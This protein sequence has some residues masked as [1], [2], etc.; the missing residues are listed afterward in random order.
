[1]AGNITKDWNF[2]HI[3][4]D[5]MTSQGDDPSTFIRPGIDWFHS[6]AA[7]YDAR[8]N[9][10][11]VSSREN[12]LIKVNYDTGNII[13]IFGDPTKYWYTFPSLRAK[14]ITLESGGLYPIG[15][16]ATSITSDGLL[17]LFND[18]QGSLNQ[19][20]NTPAGETRS[21]SAVSAY[22]IDGNALTAKEVWRF[23]YNQSIFSGVCSSAYEADDKSLL[24]NYAVADHQ[25]KARLVGLNK[26][27]DVIFD[28]EYP[29]TG[30]ATS[31]N[32]VPVN[33]EKMQF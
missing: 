32:A 31:W 21:Y 16:H 30:C 13:W 11:I 24:V 10:V 17:M 12:F 6:N 14:A 1:M 28:F 27:H 5:Y 33:F 8:D 29:T 25:T 15:Q 7:T 3:L 4:R 2:A 9:S 26:N 20:A 18:G 22:Q 19:P 23:D